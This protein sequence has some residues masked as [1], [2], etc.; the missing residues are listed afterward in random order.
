MLSAS[1]ERLKELWLKAAAAGDPAE[2]EPILSEFR[3]ALHEYIDAKVK[4]G[5]KNPPQWTRLA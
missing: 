3:D 4:A 1:E 5:A 2:V